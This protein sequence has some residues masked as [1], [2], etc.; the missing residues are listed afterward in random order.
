MSLYCNSVQIY[1]L[2][3][4]MSV[5]VMLPTQQWCRI[6]F[7]KSKN[8]KSYSILHLPTLL[9]HPKIVS[10]CLLDCVDNWIL[11]LKTEDMVEW[12]FLWNKLLYFSSQQREEVYSLLDRISAANYEKKRKYFGQVFHHF[13]LNAI[14]LCTKL[15]EILNSRAP[16]FSLLFLHIS[17]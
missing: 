11:L 13:Y 7:G 9:V 8:T 16:V 3:D 12:N 10:V 14:F 1:R 15:F 4:R 17:K 6:I 2:P 5:I